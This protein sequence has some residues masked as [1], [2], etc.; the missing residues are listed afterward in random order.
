MIQMTDK[1]KFIKECKKYGWT[2]NKGIK[3]IALLIDNLGPSQTAVST[4][5]ET[6]DLIEKTAAVCPSIYYLQSYRPCIE[7][8]AA[9]FNSVNIS[10]FVGDAIALDLSS[11]QSL[12]RAVRS[13]KYWYITDIC[14]LFDGT[15]SQYEKYLLDDNIIKFT[16]S[17]DY[18]VELLKRGYKIDDT[19][20]DDFNLET[21]LEVLNAKK[22]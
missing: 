2:E 20:I 10:S 18:L 16:R 4:I 7:S 13:R 3:Q 6:N 21:I 11:L 9:K 1:Y 8:K 19:I 5:I 22:K 14:F 17:N 15:F 12:D